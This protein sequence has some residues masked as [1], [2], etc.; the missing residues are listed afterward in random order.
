VSAAPPL[1]SQDL[2]RRR[3]RAAKPANQIDNAPT[4]AING[5]NGSTCHG[6]RKVL[7]Q[8]RAS[9]GLELMTGCEQAS[10]VWSVGEADAPWCKRNRQVQGEHLDVS[11]DCNGSTV[12]IEGPLRGNAFSDRTETR[13]LTSH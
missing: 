5:G 9:A 2:L 11:S 12:R 6:W 3:R 7:K 1:V 8:L 13:C 10:L 4:A